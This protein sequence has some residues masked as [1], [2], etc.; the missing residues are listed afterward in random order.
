MAVAVVASELSHETGDHHA[1]VS[2]GGDEGQ[3]T[4]GLVQEQPLLRVEQQILGRIE[5]TSE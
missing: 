3:D 1:E 2:E 5:F 4:G